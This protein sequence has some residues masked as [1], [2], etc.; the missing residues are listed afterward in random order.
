MLQH[1]SEGTP[2]E[3]STDSPQGLQIIFVQVVHLALLW[4]GR[5]VVE[6][7]DRVYQPH[8]VEHRSRAR[9]T[10]VL[11]LRTCRKASVKGRKRSACQ[12]SEHHCHIAHC[13][14]DTQH[15]L[16]AS[17]RQY[18]HVNVPHATYRT[19]RTAGTAVINCA[20]IREG[21]ALLGSS[22]SAKLDLTRSESWRLA[23]TCLF[24]LRTARKQKVK[25]KGT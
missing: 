23:C 24:R 18:G 15:N 20:Y 8:P 4:K 9:P 7:A 13:E 22:F 21:M 11:R 19:T 10:G 16:T 3:P 25:Q 5:K 12:S 6:L 17:K 1:A 14:G 2:A